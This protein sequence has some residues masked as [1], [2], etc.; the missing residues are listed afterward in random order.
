MKRLQK[1]LRDVKRQKAGLQKSQCFQGFSARYEKR[2][3][4]MIGPHNPKVVGSNPSSATKIPRKFNASGDFSFLELDEIRNLWNICGM[5]HVFCL[6]CEFFP[7][8]VHSNQKL[9]F[10][11]YSENSGGIDYEYSYDKRKPPSRKCL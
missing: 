2:Q 7:L 9:I 1:A 11:E 6:P 10:V 8:M 4:T 3:Q 5:R